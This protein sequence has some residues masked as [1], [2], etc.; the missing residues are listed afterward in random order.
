MALMEKLKSPTQTVLYSPALYILIPMKNLQCKITVCNLLAKMFVIPTF[1]RYPIL[2]PWIAHIKALKKL[3]TPTDFDR[4]TL[5]LLVSDL[6]SINCLCYTL[7]AKKLDGKYSNLW[8]GI[9]RPP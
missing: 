8:F 9:P 3:E 4:N 7:L 6:K 2:G 1:Y 5:G